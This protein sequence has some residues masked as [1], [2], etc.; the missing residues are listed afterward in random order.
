MKRIAKFLLLFVVTGLLTISCSRK[1]VHMNKHRKSRHC[2]CPTFAYQ[3]N[4][5]QAISYAATTFTDD[6]GGEI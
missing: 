6:F 2:N 5:E 4:A 3:M 1:G